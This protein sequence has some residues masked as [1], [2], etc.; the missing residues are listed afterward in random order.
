MDDPDTFLPR[1]KYAGSVF[2]LRKPGTADPECLIANCPH[3]GCPVEYVADT[4]QFVCPCHGSRF[5]SDG[6][7]LEGPAKSGLQAAECQVE[8]GQIWVRLRKQV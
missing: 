3:A 4:K 7:L 5:A 2:L 1:A 8:A 6:T